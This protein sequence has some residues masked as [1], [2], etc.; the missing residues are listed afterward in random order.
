MGVIILEN[1]TTSVEDYT[2]AMMR[3]GLAIEQALLR[4][5]IRILNSDDCPAQNVEGRIESELMRSVYCAMSKVRHKMKNNYKII[6][7]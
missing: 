5:Y 2:E 4:M 6:E 3:D 1:N 7:D